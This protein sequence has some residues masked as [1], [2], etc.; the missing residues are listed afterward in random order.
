MAVI[1]NRSGQVLVFER[2]DRRGEWQFPQ[3]GLEG[4]E[5]VED[6]LRRELA[7]EIG[8]AEIEILARTASWVKYR[9]P[10]E[11]RRIWESR[12]SQKSSKR[13]SHLGQKQIWFLCRFIGRGRPRLRSS[14]GTF[15]QAKWVAAN[16]A[17]RCVVEWKQEAYRKGLAE[18]ASAKLD[19]V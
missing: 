17:V 4:D 9:F 8:S 6:A 2:S 3:G 13:R 1:I 16:D 14:D 11:V 12:G 5:S 19:D 18:L 10:A 15:V 7:E